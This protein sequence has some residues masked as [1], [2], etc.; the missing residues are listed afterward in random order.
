MPPPDGSFNVPLI[1]KIDVLYQKLYLLGRQIPKRDKFGIW[2]KIENLCLD[3]LEIIIIASLEKK[4]NKGQPLN[5]ARIKIE[6]LKRMIRIT[7]E[8]KIIEARKY[9][10]LETELQEISK[11]TSGWIKYLNK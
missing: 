2:I 3:L 1:H 9:I 10:E 11:M 4:I 8:L 5:A 6:I 7:H